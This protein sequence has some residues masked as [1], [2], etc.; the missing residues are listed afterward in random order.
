[1]KK[2]VLHLIRLE[3]MAEI[4][5]LLAWPR[6]L[7]SCWECIMGRVQRRTYQY[8]LSHFNRVIF[9]KPGCDHVIPLLYSAFK[10]LSK[11]LSAGEAQSIRPSLH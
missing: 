2:Y 10:I 3:I 8:Y 4:E 5:M 9:S 7:L 1:M 6:P 11:F